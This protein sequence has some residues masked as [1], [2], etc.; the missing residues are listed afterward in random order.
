MKKKKPVVELI[1][2]D[3]NA[4][5]IIA[6]TRKALR[7]AGYSAE[8]IKKYETEAMSGDYDKLIRV[9]MDWVD[10]R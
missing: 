4:F 6:R 7:T 10:V 1:N 3:G 2:N 8:D 5:S 9:T